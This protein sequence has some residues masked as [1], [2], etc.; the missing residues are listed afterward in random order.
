MKRR[1]GRVAMA[2]AALALVG[3]GG[4]AYW[5]WYVIPHRVDRAIAEARRSGAAGEVRVRKEPLRRLGQARPGVTALTSTADWRDGAF[6]FG[7]VW[8]ATSGGVVALRTDGAWERTVTWAD[9]LGAADAT[10]IVRHGGRLA[11]GGGDGSITLLDD[12]QAQVVRFETAVPG[13]AITDLVSDG[14][15]LYAGTFGAGLIVWDGR[16]AAALTAAGGT[17]IAEVTALA[18]GAHGLAVGTSAGAVLVRREGRLVPLALDGTDRITAL[19]WDGDALWVGTP[20]GLRNVA[21]DGTVSVARRDIFVTSLL[22]DRAIGRLYVGTFDGGVALHQTQGGGERAMGGRQRI[23]RIRMIDDRPVAF[24]PGGAWQL[25]G[26]FTPLAAGVPAGL[27]GGHVT[28]LMARGGEIWA[29]TF[30]NGVDVFDARGQLLR[31]LPP[32]GA[33]YGAEQVNAIDA[34]GRDVIL[35]TVRGLWIELDRGG[36]ARFGVKDGLIGEQVQDIAVASGG[37][38]YATNRGVTVVGTDAVARSIYALQGLANNH[39]YAVAWGTD[40]RL[41]AGTLG[42]VSV[43]SPDLIVERSYG[44]AKHEL[45]A[46][47]V[48]ALAATPEGIYAGTYGGGVARLTAAGEVENLGPGRHV[49]VN[50]G[51]MLVDGDRLYAGTL[52][53]GLL[54]YDRGRREWRAVELPLG[55]RSVTALAVAGD[56][57]WI[58]TDRGLVRVETQVIDAALQPVGES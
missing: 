20:F 40:G 50:P 17:P 46:A 52:E 48:T 33:A 12:A 10:A 9:G 2:I 24:G 6:A 36:T 41:Y 11:V 44:A 49:R 31:H 45:R 38:A 39:C 16:K 53:D 13:A 5:I 51:A 27:S 19:A 55:S 26:D 23:E 22:A 25:T 47:W 7:R 15:L 57:L 21:G 42:G 30:E 37:A 14:E 18:L 8:A 35:A 1:F 56:V 29:G 54:V 58:G 32:A 4:A 28:A 43:L 34:R 3:A